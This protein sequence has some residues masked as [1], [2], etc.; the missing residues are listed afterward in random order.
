MK[1][2][3]GSMSRWS[4]ASMISVRL[5]EVSAGVAQ[6]PRAP[7]QPGHALVEGRR[8]GMEA[9]VVEQRDEVDPAGALLADGDVIAQLHGPVTFHDHLGRTVDRAQPGPELRGVGHGRR[10]TYEDDV[11]RGQDDGLLPDRSPVGVLEVVHLVQHQEAQ[12]GQ[13]RGAGEEHVAHH[14]GG[15][16]DDLGIGLVRHV[17]REQP[18]AVGA[19]GGGQFG[20]LLVGQGLERCRVEGLAPA[21]RARAMA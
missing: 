17:A 7:G 19:V 14:F 4:R 9:A 8:L 11:V 16:D 3:A 1:T 5:G 20:E 18:D 6:A 13:L 12:P 15:H 10:Q 21:A 2:M